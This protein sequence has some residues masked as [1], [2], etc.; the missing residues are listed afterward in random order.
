[1]VEA[2]ALENVVSESATARS[3]VLIVSNRLPVS[4]RWRGGRPQ[5]LPSTGGL[6]TGLSHV[7]QQE[8]T[9]WIGWSG[10]SGGGAQ[11][12]AEV[13][14]L[15][16][17][18]SLVPIRLSSDEIEAFYDGFSNGLVWPLF[19]YLMERVRIRTSDWDSYRRVNERFADVV[20]DQ[21]QPGDQVWIHD[22]H[23]ML[24]PALLRARLPSAQIGF[25]L[26][27]P[28]PADDIFRTLPWRRE[29]LEGLLGADVVGFHTAGYARH[30]LS[31]VRRIL[32]IESTSDDLWWH[33]RPVHVAAFPMGID[34][35]HFEAIAIRPDVRERT[36]AIRSEARARRIFLGV[37]RLDYT[38][39]IPGR[40]LAFQ[41]LLE[42]EPALRK[43]V[44]FIQVAVPS[45]VDAGAYRTFRRELDELIGRINGT[46]G[47]VESV[48]IHY[49]Y[50][51]ISQSE[52]V[53]LYNA[54]DVMMVT[55]LRDGMNLVAKEFIA[56]R[57]DND[58]V[59]ILSEFAGA[60]D[61]L[62]DALFVNPYDVDGV[63]QAMASALAMDAEQRRT[64]MIALRAVV[65][66]STVHDWADGFLNQLSQSAVATTG[67]DA[68]EDAIQALAAGS[69]PD[70]GPVTLLLDYD[71]TLVPYAPTPEGAKPDA[72]LLQLLTA[73]GANTDISLHLVSGRSIDT[74]NQWFASL[75]AELWAEHGAAHRQSTAGAWKL[76]VPST[77]EWIARIRPILEET[78]AETP[79]ALVEE[80]STSIAW[81]Y[82]RVEPGVAARQLGRVRQRA[83]RIVDTCPVEMLDGRMV[84]EF[85]PRGVSKGLVVR[86]IIGQ[87]T[88]GPLVAIGD[89]KTDEDMFA[90]LPKSGI[91]IRVG[92]GET[93][94][95]YRLADCD[96]V[97]RLLERLLRRAGRVD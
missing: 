22:Y 63:A 88:E 17:E 91:A 59:L 34:T 30:F 90:A 1:M 56:S 60:G 69:L 49:L 97:R 89:D 14:Q 51:S 46:Y 84:L 35:G 42:R 53:A 74:L 10:D 92:D 21:W 43:D 32:A 13:D 94:A 37:D 64:R 82:R 24:V 28:F 66:E 31:S 15:L 25:F 9:L 96:A 81:H 44:R 73:L 61:E 47:S 70:T 55:P 11:R 83:Q 85:R 95:R 40:L 80:K 78:T 7:Q 79:G 48:P 45:R 38:K 52:L 87:G 4:V 33:S 3:R 39:G 18:R 54:A 19:H 23:L 68:P 8:G 71:G 62:S 2:S 41:R 5:L 26:H 57:I 12:A 20:A 76:L 65:H 29:L 58:G 36:A 50:R 86:H 16:R 75:D 77:K 93:T 27:I 6:A 72:E 67:L